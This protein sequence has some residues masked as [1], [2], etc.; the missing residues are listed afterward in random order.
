MAIRELNRNEF[1]S[2]SGAVAAE[3]DPDGAACAVATAKVASDCLQAGA[4]E[5]GDIGK[6]ASCVIGVAGLM[7]AGC[8][9]PQPPSYAADM[10]NNA[11]AQAEARQKAAADAAEAARINTEL[12]KAREELEKARE[13]LNRLQKPDGSEEGGSGGR[14]RVM[15]EASDTEDPDEYYDYC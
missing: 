5:G 2:V 13:E 1:L 9:T 3:S 10:M 8:V 7:V 15:E 6:D 14:D 4:K 12:Q 11:Q